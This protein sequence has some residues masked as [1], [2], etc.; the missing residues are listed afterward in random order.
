MGAVYPGVH[1]HVRAMDARILVQ[2]CVSVR[3]VYMYPNVC[4]CAYKDIDNRILIIP[5]PNHAILNA[6]VLVVC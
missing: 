3:L 2:K 4:Q 1:I 5:N 6:F